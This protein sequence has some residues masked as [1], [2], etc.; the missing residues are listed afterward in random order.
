[1]KPCLEITWRKDAGEGDWIADY[2][3]VLPLREL[4]MRRKNGSDVLRVSLGG[5]EVHTGNPIFP[6]EV[7]G[8]VAIPFRDGAHV[9][10]DAQV[11]GLEAFAVY[12]NLRTPI[13][14]TENV[15]SG[16]QWRT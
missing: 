8:S 10:W 6:I 5:T 11:L 1:M 15:P 12:G 9:K 16:G 14:I 13:D 2:E 3:L 7:D 4:D